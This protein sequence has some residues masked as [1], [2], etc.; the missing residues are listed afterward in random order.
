MRNAFAAAMVGLA[1][2]PDTVFLTGDLGFMAL[3]PVRE[4]LG[5]RFLNCGVAEQNMV[6]MAAALA[7]EGLQP[8]VYS[9]A[10]F[11]YARPFEQVRIDVCLHALPV[12]LAGNGG[13][14]GY[15]A[16]GPTHHAIEDCAVMCA[17]PGMRVFV[18]A[19]ARDIGPMVQALQALPGPAYLRLG[20]D[21]SGGEEGLPAYAPWRRLVSGPGPLVCVLGPLVW[22]AVRAARD[23]PEDRRPEVWAV[24][25]LPVAEVP[26]P[27][28]FLE[29][30]ASGKALCL[31]EEH[32]AVGGLGSQLALHLALAGVPVRGL[33]HLHA[34]N[35]QP[36]AYGSQ[37]WYR[38]QLGLDGAGMVRALDGLQG[39]RP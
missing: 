37:A 28:A 21:E 6:S 33:V 27:P 24:S 39:P 1:A 31:A 26:P 32:V 34:G 5:R 38:R 22:E 13:G 11:V 18:P 20:R 16:Q 15:G 3:E 7:R 19:F 14:F 25:E 35:G 8:W 2:R 4:A 9:I 10:P 12:R 23:L 30:L 29:A 17:L 36:G